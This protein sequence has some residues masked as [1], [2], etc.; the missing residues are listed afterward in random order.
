MKYEIVDM[1]DTLATPEFVSFAVTMQPIGDEG[2]TTAAVV[3]R[4]ATGRITVDSVMHHRKDSLVLR[5]NATP[6]E[7]EA[8]QSDEVLEF[9]LEALDAAGGGVALL[10]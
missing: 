10:N 5:T 6:S 2:L 7:L 4:R 8:L 1:S 9:A 3:Y